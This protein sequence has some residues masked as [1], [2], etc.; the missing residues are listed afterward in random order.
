MLTARGEP[1]GRL[2][3]ALGVAFGLAVLVGN[4]IGMGILRTPGE[5]AARLPS[6]PLF[7]AVW[8]AG[9]VYAL[10][11]AL[12][13]AELAAMR[14]R[15][16]GLYPLVHDALGEYP[17]FIVGWTDWLATC[18]SLAAVAMVLGE[19]AGPLIPGMT[20][21]EWVTASTVVAGFALLQWR[22]IR[23]G[24][25]AQ[26]L[27]SLVKFLALVALAGVAFAVG[28]DSTPLAPVTGSTAPTGFALVG[29]VVIALQS[30]IYTYDGWTGPIYF[31]EEMRDPA[32]DI[33][34][35][36]VAG[37]LL[38]LAIYLLLNAAFLRVMPIQDMAGDPFVAATAARRL[39]GPT[40]DT[41][42]R[43]VMVLSLIAAVNALQLMASRVPFAMSRDRLL[44]AVLHRVN[45]GGTP[46]PA[47]VASTLV[48]LACIATNTFDTLV[49]MLAF[50]FV[51]NYGLA[52][53]AL[54]AS[55]QR[56]IDAPR[57]FRVPGYPFVPGVALAG[58]IAFMAAA[59]VSDRTNSMLSLALLGISWPVYRLIRRSTAATA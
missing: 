23:S 56:A 3:K 31:G 36:M 17:A 37:V 22:G 58:S 9:A 48:A 20:G 46:V 41:V 54:F 44:P 55:R 14:P 16:G 42:I 26:Q 24:D 12:T 53:T 19:Y 34:R 6:V 51:A 29:A 50:L 13:V 38:V 4:T 21:R 25:A 15:S 10:L 7:I 59:I 43:I 32:R 57:P 18:G 1:A 11:G 49:A 40:G 2:L 35:T 47:L 28:I 5:V 30:A 52:F 8:V 33:P 45:P 39:F 27:T